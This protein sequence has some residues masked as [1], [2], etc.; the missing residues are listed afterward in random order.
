M[1]SRILVLFDILSSTL[2]EI[3]NPVANISL[4]LTVFYVEEFSKLL[5]TIMHIYVPGNL[6]IRSN[7]KL[8][9]ATAPHSSTLAWRIPWMEEPSVL[10]FMGSPRVRHS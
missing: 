10:Q 5:F 1:S 4:Y 7:Y 6:K 8:E 9:K 3:R 2:H